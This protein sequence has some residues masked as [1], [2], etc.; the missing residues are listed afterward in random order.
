[1]NKPLLE[2]KD[3]LTVIETTY[4]A[5]SKFKSFILYE[6]K[7]CFLRFTFIFSSFVLLSEIR[8]PSLLVTLISKIASLISH[9]DK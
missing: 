1:M 6:T 4:L 8:N 2:D 3:F 7:P 9:L 5:G